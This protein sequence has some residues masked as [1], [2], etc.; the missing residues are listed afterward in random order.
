VPREAEGEFVAVE[1]SLELSGSS[2]PDRG[3]LGSLEMWADTASLAE[4]PCVVIDAQ[5]MVVA[6]SAGCRQL[7]DIDTDEAVGCA[8]AGEVFD[9]R[10]FSTLQRSLPDWEISKIPPLLAVSSAGLSRG[11][12]RV[13]VGSAT[14]TVDAVSVPLVDSGAIVG[15]LT[16]FLPV[17]Q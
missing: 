16:F 2:P 14:K 8:L 3:T 17:N 13:W 11:L 4:E 6:A 10:D 9:L 1:L 12:L 5:G 15:S 7:F